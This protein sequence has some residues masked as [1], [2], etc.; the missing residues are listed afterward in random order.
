MYKYSVTKCLLYIL[1]D[2]EVQ[3]L[4]HLQHAEALMR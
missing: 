3:G 2:N 4:A 1:T